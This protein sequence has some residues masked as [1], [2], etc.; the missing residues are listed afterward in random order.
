MLAEAA[1]YRPQAC[2]LDEGAMLAQAAVACVSAWDCVL[3]N[4]KCSQKQQLLVHRPQD[5]VLGNTKCWQKQQ[6]LAFPPQDGVV[7]KGDH[8]G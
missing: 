1:V 6:L 7:D 8:V 3:G 2:V 4:T 5:C